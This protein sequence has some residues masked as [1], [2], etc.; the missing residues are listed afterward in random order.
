V[1]ACGWAI[2]T[3]VLN[4]DRFVAVVESLFKHT[5][6][7]VFLLHLY[8]GDI[9]SLG[10]RNGGGWSLPAQADV[11]CG[12]GVAVVVSARHCTSFIVQIL[13]AATLIGLKE[14]LQQ[15][16]AAAQFHICG[17]GGQT[18][19]GLI[20]INAF[21]L[22]STASIIVLTCINLFAFTCYLVL[23]LQS[24]IRFICI[25]AKILVASQWTR[26]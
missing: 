7:S 13:R 1:H 20:L 21:F 22:H 11:V 2:S 26:S 18:Q 8:F 25:A 5:D 24:F 14:R 10:V 4:S 19:T 3:P 9:R 6:A 12:V 16:Q 23:S 15:I 17:R